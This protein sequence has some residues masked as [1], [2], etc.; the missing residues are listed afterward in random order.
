MYQTIFEMKSAKKAG[1]NSWLI[2]IAKFYYLEEDE[3]DVTLIRI[4]VGKFVTFVKYSLV[5]RNVVFSLQHQ[6]FGDG[7]L[8]YQNTIRRGPEGAES[9]LNGIPYHVARSSEVVVEYSHG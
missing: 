8:A 1:S 3:A 7:K 6:K 4:E 9:S 2:D 5:D